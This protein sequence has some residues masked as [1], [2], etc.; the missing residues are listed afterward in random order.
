[1]REPADATRRRVLVGTTAAV[2]TALA[3]CG[4]PGDGGD[5]GFENE[6]ADGGSPP[7][8]EGENA[9]GA[10]EGNA[11]GDDND[12]ETGGS[13]YAPQGNS[14]RASGNQTVSERTPE[15]DAENGTGENASGAGA[16]GGNGS[17]N[18]S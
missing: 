4:S 16:G 14:T 13:E 8:E 2:A 12:S 15:D 18:E 7:A 6:G 3:G 11:T 9:S 10:G 1:M 17:Q 5:G